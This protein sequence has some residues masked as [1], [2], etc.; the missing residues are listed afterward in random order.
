MV[1]SSVI[2][3]FVSGLDTDLSPW[4][5]P[6]DSFQELNNFH[7][8]DGYLEKRRGFRKFGYMV[9]NP[10]TTITAITEAN[11]AEVTAGSHGLADG[12]EVLI[13]NVAG[14]T[15][16]NGLIFTVANK[17]A[18]TFELSGVNSTAYTTY[19]SGGRV[20]L[21]DGNRIMG[22]YKYYAADATTNIFVFD[23][24]RAAIYD[25]TNE[26]FTP[27][28]AADVLDGGVD[29]FVWAANWQAPGGSNRLYFTN[30]LELATAKNGIRY[31]DPSVSTTATT[32]LTPSIGGGRSLYGGKL[33][34]VLK[35]R[36]VVLNT[37]E[38]S[39]AS[40]SNY[41]QRARWCQA[42]DPSSWS[43]IV[44]GAGGYV[45][46]PVGEHILSARPLQDG[47]IVFFTK[48]VWTLR[49]VSDPALPFRWDR[50]NDVAGCNNKMG[51]SQFDKFVAGV[52]IRGI[53]AT[54][55][56]ESQRIDSRILNFTSEQ[57][58]ADEFEKVFCARNH[59][60]KHWWT[61]YPNHEDTENTGALIFE[62]DSNAFSLYQ[63]SMNC[64]GYGNLSKDY[65]IEDFTVAN[66]LD[67]AIEDFTDENLQSYFWQSE[68]E[69][70]LGG[71]ISGVVHIMDV[72]GS[73]DGVDIDC[74]LYSAA[75]NPYLKENSKAQLNYVDLYVD[76]SKV[77]QI[78]VEFFKDTDET[79]YAT[80]QS[81]LLPPLD[82]VAMISNI[83]QAN[84]ASVTADSHGLVT[85]DKIYIY[86]VVGMTEVEDGF[87]ITVVNSNT[88]TLDDINSSAYTA[89]SHGGQVV[90]RKYYRDKTWKRIMA[91]GTGFQHRMKISNTGSATPLK[92]EG[93][94]PAFR[95]KAYGRA[96]N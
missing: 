7:I 34:F 16:V 73:D 84:P 30:G 31:Y 79:P 45:D 46:A 62:E 27:L 35:E 70:F 48:S 21:Y 6:P 86:G 65:A 93:F 92:I 71:D 25:G 19:T 20:A 28:D 49:P 51:T 38:F 61:L 32:A 60:T 63:I 68:H 80:Q 64:L 33:L 81:D 66:N 50:I 3:P 17:T 54:N 37:H 91:G 55:G 41:P 12:D 39:G 15:E 76:N 53:T 57:I 18:N 85:G 10:A 22:I 56:S 59:N 89:Y 69:L 82:F 77:S 47:L 75:W 96:I 42:Q 94:A 14:M 40:T 72:G 8:K 29:D 67:L 78:T 23:T 13:T 36:L 24:E 2:A 90:R 44:A 95:K 43:D 88:F 1:N 58:N 83:T 4:L 26:R 87:T 5:A 9:H 52:S 74:S 11:P